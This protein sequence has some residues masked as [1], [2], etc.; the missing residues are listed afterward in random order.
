MK[1]NRRLQVLI[2]ALWFG[3]LS[4]VSHDEEEVARKMASDTPLRVEIDRRGEPQLVVAVPPRK[5]TAQQRE[6]LA[7]IAT[8]FR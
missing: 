1:R 3:L 5:L 8:F 2:L 7:Q 4:L 6:E